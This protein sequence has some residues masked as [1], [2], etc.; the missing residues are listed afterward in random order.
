MTNLCPEGDAFLG[1]GTP[2][3]SVLEDFQICTQTLALASLVFKKLLRSDMSEAQ[4]ILAGEKPRISLHNDDYHA[5]EIIL[6]VL[7]YCLGAMCPENLDRAARIAILSNKYDC[8]RIFR[9]WLAY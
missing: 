7:Y 2:Q 5:M 3:D 6:R 4:A 8:T 9:P 1:L